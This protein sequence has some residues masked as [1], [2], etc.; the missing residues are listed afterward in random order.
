MNKGLLFLILIFSFTCIQAQLD[1]AKV[2]DYANPKEYTIG[3][4]TISGVKFLD[5]N[6]LRSLSGLVVGDKIS[7]PSVEITKAV[8]KF[9]AQGLFSD[10]K[11]AVDSFVNDKVFLNVYLIERPRIT[12][13]EIIGVKKTDEK[14]L[15]EQI[16][17]KKGSQ[18][19][20]NLLKKIEYTIKNEFIDRGFYNVT[21]SFDQEIDPTEP[22][23]VNLK[24][25]INKNAK[26]K[27]NDVKFSGNVAFE[28]NR[29]ERTLKKTREKKLRYIFNSSKLIKDEYRQDKQKLIDF[30]NER[31]YRDAKIVADSIVSY[32]DERIDI[33][34]HVFEGRKYFF[35]EIKWVGNTKYSTDILQQ[36]LGVKRGDIYDQ[37]LMNKRLYEDED[38]A[39]S[40]YLNNGYLF[41]NIDPVEVLIEND[42][43]DIEMRVF[44]G[45][46]ASLNNVA[47][48]GNTKTNEHVIRRELR[49]K[50]GELFSKQDI[51]RSVRELAQLGH[52]DPE[53]I[54]PSPVP[55]QQE[56]NVDINYNLTEKANDQL[57]LSGGYGAGMLIGTIG[58]QFNN[59]SAKN[60]FKGDA[61]RPIP[62]GDGQKLGISARTNGRYYQAYSL[63]FVE[64]WFGGKKPNSFSFNVFHSV[65]N[66]SSY[67][68][69]KSDKFLKMTGASI[70]LGKR[71]K[72]P[73]DYFTL[74]NEFSYQNYFLDNWDTDFIFTDG[75]SNNFSVTHSLSRNSVDQPIYPRRGSNFTLSLQWTP[76]YSLFN[77]KDYSGMSPQEKYS[78]IEYH[79]WK[80]SS[81]WYSSLVGNL[82]LYTR[83]DF[84]YLAYFNKTIGPSP[85]ESFDLGGDGLQGYNLYGRELVSLRGYEDKSLTPLIN[86]KRS[87]NIYDRFTIEL[88]Y[89]AVLSTSAT[90]YGIG[91]LE[92][93]NAWYSGKTFNPF[94]MHRSLGVGVRAF[95]PMFGLL[96]V[97][98]GYGFD[99]VQGNP[100]A[101][102]GHF[103]FVIG[104]Q[105]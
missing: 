59:F 22:Q 41:S 84:G 71:L 77:N 85:F 21:V 46:Q 72:F 67:I 73:D 13:F 104:Q 89:P 62:S 66:N 54:E 49:T 105:F 92:A 95:L 50:P 97:D 31:G 14:D 27:I 56:G 86:G 30:Y 34:I 88:R 28:E 82:V 17:L 83:F 10:V 78:W 100:D 79:K 4:V 101:H 40:L 39:S 12:D 93:G 32:N 37:K 98:W 3:A 99:E 38:A 55:N 75:S 33:Y 68:Y 58:V 7:I 74:Y 76:P 24:I 60:F 6:A 63:N 20:D 64:P 25:K 8:K 91:F 23:K 43:I 70:G 81:N 52:F 87:G 47:I 61:W 11:I 19:T 29:L 44:E 80:Y 57:Q 15:I 1:Q 102:K 5:V 51:I 53:K 18:L 2:I 103:H 26:V 16:A 65:Y 94:D 90:V 9:Y 96:G 45:R 35:R 42:S 48:A 36:L 69:E